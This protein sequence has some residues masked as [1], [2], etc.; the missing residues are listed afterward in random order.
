MTNWDSL[1]AFDPSVDEIPEAPHGS[2]KLSYLG[3]VNDIFHDDP[4]AFY[5]MVDRGTEIDSEEFDE[6][7]FGLDEFASKRGYD[8]CPDLDIRN[9]YA[10]TFYKSKYRGETCAY[11]QWSGYEYVWI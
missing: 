9:D 3:C 8:D 11:M 6:L 5:G 10:V 1:S 4:D 2:D 7:C